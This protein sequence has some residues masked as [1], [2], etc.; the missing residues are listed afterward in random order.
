M[1]DRDWPE[2]ARFHITQA[3]LWVTG[4]EVAILAFTWIPLQRREAWSFWALVALGICA[5]VNHFVAAMALP[6]G[7]PPSKGNVYDWILGLVLLMYAAGL[8]WAA[9]S[10]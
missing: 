7:R 9:T 6:K 2:H 10:M 1:R 5:Q 8:V 4:L 3:F